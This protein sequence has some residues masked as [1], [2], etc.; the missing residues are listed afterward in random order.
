M[1]KPLRVFHDQKGVSPK[2]SHI[3][4]LSTKVD[5]GQVETVD[6]NEAVS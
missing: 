6:S 1:K 3:N 5:Q 4:G 2:R